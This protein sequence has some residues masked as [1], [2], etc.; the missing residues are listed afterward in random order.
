PLGSLDL[1]EHRAGLRLPRRPARCARALGADPRRQGVA[2]P[3]RGAEHLE[4]LP[5]RRRRP[6]GTLRGLAR[7]QPSAGPP[8]PAAGDPPH[9]PLL[10][11]VHGLRRPRPRRHGPADRGGQGPMTTATARPRSRRALPREG[12]FRWVL[13]WGVPLRVMHWL[14]AASIVVLAVT[15][16]YIGKPYFIA[17]GDTADHFLMGRVRFIHFVAGAVLVMTGIVRIYWLFAG[18]RFERWHALFP[19]SAK[20]IRHMATQ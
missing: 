5:A 3:V 4:L 15:G 13:L 9:D 11:P 10:R 16:L 20:A 8:R 12:D 14:A 6:D 18:N 7:R 19:V 1:A 17:G 2:L